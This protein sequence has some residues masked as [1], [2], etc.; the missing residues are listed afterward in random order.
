M[1]SVEGMQSVRKEM[2]EK[3]V[4]EKQTAETV[5]RG[6]KQSEVT[7]KKI[8]QEKEKMQKMEELRY[9]RILHMK[10]TRRFAAFPFLQE[11]I[12]PISAK[13]TVAE[14]V[15]TDELQKL[16]LDLQGSQQRLMGY[17]TQG[18][19]LME[20][21]WGDGSKMTF[22]PPQLRLDLTNFGKVVSTDQ[23]MQ[24]AQPLI[25]E[26]IIEYPGIG[27]MGLAMRWTQCILNSMFMV[28]QMNTNPA[29]KR[30]CEQRGEGGPAK[31]AMTKEEE[32]E[33]SC[34]GSEE[35]LEVKVSAAPKPAPATQMPAS[36]KTRMLAA[37]MAQK[38]KSAAV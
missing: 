6:Q 27:Q 18:G 26:T 3:Q 24:E 7:M 22:L 35:E 31:P 4:E 25:Q 37:L 9:A 13:A 20:S 30:M 36:E 19:F 12:P 15:E 5:R 29:F 38:K 16:E 23:F 28:H 17:I 32:A 1:F 8:A 2:L 11:K 10:V 34:S 21:L 33:E 14:L